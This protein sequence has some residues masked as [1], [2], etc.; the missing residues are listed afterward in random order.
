MLT[1]EL[2]QRILETMRRKIAELAPSLTERWEKVNLVN[3]R[4]WRE[5]LELFTHSVGVDCV[6]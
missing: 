6:T 5:R 1:K 2:P 3:L 4:H